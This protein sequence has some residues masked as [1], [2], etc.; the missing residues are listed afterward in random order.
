MKHQCRGTDRTINRVGQALQAK[1]GLLARQE[2]KGIE[3]DSKAD[4]LD[5][6]DEKVRT[7]TKKRK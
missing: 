3:N 7:R 4:S 6:N 5:A 1:E 2:R